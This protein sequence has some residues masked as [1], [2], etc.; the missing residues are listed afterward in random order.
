MSKKIKRACMHAFQ[1]DI[2]NSEIKEQQSQF[3]DQYY[4][5]SSF[6]IATKMSSSTS[7]CA[8]HSVM[9]KSVASKSEAAKFCVYD[10][11]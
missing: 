6:R 1:V 7:S 2:Q 3:V 9:H 11:S 8:S 4:P 5:V 10:P